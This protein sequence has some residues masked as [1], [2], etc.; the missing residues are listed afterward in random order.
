VGDYRILYEIKSE[1]LLVVV[2]KVGH[3]RDVY[4]GF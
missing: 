3:R 2:I 4:R 1:T